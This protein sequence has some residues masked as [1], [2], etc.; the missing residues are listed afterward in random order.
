MTRVG[1]AALI[2]CAAALPALAQAPAPT[3]PAAAART[4]PAVRRPPTHRHALA[5]A[6]PAAAPVWSVDKAASRLTFQ[7]TAAGQQFDGVFKTWD[8]QIAFDPKNLKASH[9]MISVSTAS[10]ITGEPARDQALPGPDWFWSK[11]YPK[12]VFVSHSLTP[13]SP[14]HFQA[15]GVLSLRG[16]RRRI[17]APITLTTDS[18]AA[19]LQGEVLIDRTEFGVGRGAAARAVGPLIKVTVRLTG[20]PGR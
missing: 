3:R 14:G 20:K 10:A 7:G 18:D 9:I 16:V 1:L 15:V 11:R 17:A 8:A 5:P 6:A 12:A 4:R 2:L 19:T 13:I